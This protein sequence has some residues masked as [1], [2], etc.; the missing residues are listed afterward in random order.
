MTA[1]RRGAL[2]LLSA[3]ALVL[4][5]ASSAR[6]QVA[7]ETFSGSGTFNL[8]LPGTP[9]GGGVD[10]AAS[11]A[12]NTLAFTPGSVTFSGQPVDFSGT[13]ASWL[14]SSYT[15]NLQVP[16][17]AGP[18]TVNA[19][20]NGTVAGATNSNF[21]GTVQS[22]DLGPGFSASNLD[23][24]NGSSYDTDGTTNSW[25][26][27]VVPELNGAT[28]DNVCTSN[29]TAVDPINGIVNASGN[30]TIFGT[31]V[32][33]V[34]SPLGMLL[35]SAGLLGLGVLLLRRRTANA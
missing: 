15:G 17:N 1:R 13:E 3:L 16:V 9:N 22:L 28:V 12:L 10:F 14:A 2:T 32:I 34:L 26:S 24:V 8:T 27:G 23:I 18:A 33:P 20:W 35:L 29:V 31:L 21:N 19:P 25:S 6:A 7:V 30:G 11:G 5:S 4:V